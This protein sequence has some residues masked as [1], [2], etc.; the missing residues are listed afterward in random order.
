MGLNLLSNTPGARSL[1]KTLTRQ[2]SGGVGQGQKKAKEEE[3][4]PAADKA[5]KVKEKSATQLLF[6][7]KK[8][9]AEERARKVLVERQM[10]AVPKLGRGFGQG[11]LANFG[12]K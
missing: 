10:A 8:A 11:E 9:L 12:T 6:E 1:I 7:H 2:N 3:E 4:D 5:S